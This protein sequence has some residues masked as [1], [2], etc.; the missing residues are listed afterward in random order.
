[1]EYH[2]FQNQ[3]LCA[4]SNDAGVVSR[5]PVVCAFRRIHSR[6]YQCLCFRGLSKI[7]GLSQR[8]IPAHVGGS[9]AHKKPVGARLLSLRNTKNEF[10][11]H[12]WAC[13]GYFSLR[14]Q[15]AQEKNAYRCRSRLHKITNI[16][17]GGLLFDEIH[18]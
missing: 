8:W 1:M 9:M 2:L 5:M 15:P 12:C 11:D 6:L 3:L 4:T 7:F 17:G 13:A 18:T 10:W 16:E 14:V